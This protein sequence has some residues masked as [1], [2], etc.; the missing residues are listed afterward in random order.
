MKLAK[1]VIIEPCGWQ[2]LFL[3][4]HQSMRSKQILLQMASALGLRFSSS[5]FSMFFQLKLP[6]S[7][8]SSLGR[9]FALQDVLTFHQR[10]GEQSYLMSLKGG[11]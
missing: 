11:S 10:A 7:N 2:S 9:S 4:S 1:G 3:V 6:W 8:T 5:I